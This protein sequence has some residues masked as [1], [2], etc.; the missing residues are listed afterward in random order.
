[1]KREIPEGFTRNEIE[2]TVKLW[3]A[4]DVLVKNDVMPNVEMDVVHQDHY[5]DRW[6]RIGN[7]EFALT[8]EK[9]DKPHLGDAITLY[10]VNIDL[11]CE[12]CTI[13]DLREMLR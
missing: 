2:E 7:A 13:T 10:P 8:N 4:L 3:E 6:F 9:W 5:I 1:M 12:E 11:D